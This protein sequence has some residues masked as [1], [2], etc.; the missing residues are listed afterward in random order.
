MRTDYCG[1]IDTRFL[2]QTIT[3]FGW[4]HRRRDHGGVIFVDLRDREGLVQVVCDPDRVETFK[5]AETIRNEFVLKI[6]GVVRERPEGTTNSN[7]RSG[8]IEVLAHEIEVLNPSLTPPFMMDDENLSES[9]RLEHRYLD[10]RRPYMQKTIMMRHKAAMSVRE[11]LDGEGFIDIETPVLYKS[12]PEGAREFLV[13]SRIHDGQF[14]A[15]PQSPQLFKQLLMVSGYDRYYQVVKCFRDE[16]LRADRQPEFTQIDCEM[17]FVEQEDI[18]QMFEGMI[19]HIFKD[20][21]GINIT[22]KIERTTWET[23]MW[24][25]GNDKPDIRFGMPVINI[26]STF[27]LNG[28]V[29]AKGTL[30]EGGGFKVFDEAETILGITVPGGAAYTRKQLDEITEWVKRP[31]IGM[32]GMVN[33]RRN[34][35]NTYKSSVD[36]FFNEE[37]LRIIGEAAS[38][39]PGDLL[40][41]LAGPED[42]TRKAISEL[43]LY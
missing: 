21:K 34:A 1:V 19:K 9:T 42:R 7:L 18:L 24:N 39:N 12:T 37:R 41:I 5:V 17:S 3:L 38:M 29:P 11:Y 10:L 32:Q 23:A 40:L 35:D 14:Y 20:V 15:L 43:R 2:K 8:Q 31:Q 16:D 30:I 28:Q 4:A 33:I 13:P 22:E 26:K 36:K 25:Y 6:T 27:I